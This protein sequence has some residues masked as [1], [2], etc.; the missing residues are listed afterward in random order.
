MG[1]TLLRAVPV[2]A[3]ALAAVLAWGG[4]QRHLAGQAARDLA[5]NT[6]EVARLR[7]RGLAASL[8][9]TTRRVLAQGKVAANA[10]AKTTLAAADAGTADAATARVLDRAGELA[11]R[12]ASCDSSATGDREAAL[13]AVR[14]L[15]D[16]LRRADERAGILARI[17][18]ARGIAGEACQQSYEV[19][20][21]GL[22][23][24]DTS[25]YPPPKER[26]HD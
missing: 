4:W 5:S 21:E 18:D 8:S 12:A 10:T 19:L 23:A 7:E 26:S 17:A 25:P 11:A 24:R 13:S 15:A 9:E 22:Q 2:W 6:A 1:L 20:I 14:V 16:L 3:W